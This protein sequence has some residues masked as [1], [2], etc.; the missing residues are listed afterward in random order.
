M[1][2]TKELPGMEGTHDEQL[3]KAATR[4][5]KARDARVVALAKEIE[6]KKE[7]IDRMHE[8]RLDVYRDTDE[9]LTIEL[10]TAKESIKVKFGDQ[11]NDADD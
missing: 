6:V 8:L 1:A 2:R 9:E 3:S 4:Y 10:K 5:V 7:I 11:E